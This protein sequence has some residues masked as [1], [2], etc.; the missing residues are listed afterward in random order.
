MNYE[1]LEET[2]DEFWEAALYSNQR[3]PALESGFAWRWR[4]LSNTSQPIL[5]CE[6]AARRL[7]AGNCPVFPYYVAYFIPRR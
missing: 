7:S 3:K 1:F 4:M 6:G 2:R 5:I